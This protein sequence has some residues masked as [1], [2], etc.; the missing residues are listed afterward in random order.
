MNYRDILYKTYVSNNKQF[1]YG[2]DDKQNLRKLG[3]LRN[4]HYALA[5]WLSGI[6]R[7]ENVLDVACGE[8][9][10]LEWLKSEGFVN[11][12]GVDISFEQIEIA[13]LQFP[14]V[15]CGDAIDYLEVRPHQFQLITAFDIL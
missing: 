2:S 5:V 4:L 14:Q 6:S 15:I 1:L 3:N 8:G 7:E 10:V 12:C 11:L 9:N 13:R